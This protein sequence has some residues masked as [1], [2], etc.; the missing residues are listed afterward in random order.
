[1][2][3]FLQDV[4]RGMELR[5]TDQRSLLK[6]FQNRRGELTSPEAVASIQ[7]R[8]APDS[9]DIVAYVRLLA[10]A[11]I[12]LTPEMHASVFHPDDPSTV[13]SAPDFCSVYVEQLG[14]DAGMLY[15]QRHVFRY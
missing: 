8:C 12:R 10:S 6:I 7:P 13:I 14:Q 4:I 15:T 9:D 2:Y 1:M 3:R 5:K 11:Y